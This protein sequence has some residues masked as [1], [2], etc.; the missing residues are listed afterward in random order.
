MALAKPSILGSALAPASGSAMAL[1]RVL[2]PKEQHGAR[3]GLLQ[4]PS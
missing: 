1:T 2:N 3:S 4:W